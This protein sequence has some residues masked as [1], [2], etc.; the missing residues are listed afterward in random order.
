MVRSY[1][2]SLIGE[3]GVGKTSIALRQVQDSFPS[4]HLPTLGTNFHIWK[5]SV[6]GEDI[7]LL[8]ADTGSQEKYYKVLPTYFKNSAA[9]ALIFDITRRRTFE[10]INFWYSMLVE[11][12]GNIPFVI[13]GNK[14]DLS[15]E[16]VIKIEEAEKLAEK[17][18]SQYFEVS[19]KTKD[20]LD[21]MFR[22]LA[23]LAVNFVKQSK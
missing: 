17:L 13:V 23:N 3:P 20:N 8:I 4:V 18:N 7:K 10:R 6:G 5:T 12:V 21:K 22:Q 15:H 11:S 1:K 16:R 14:S 2:V 9:A 19:A